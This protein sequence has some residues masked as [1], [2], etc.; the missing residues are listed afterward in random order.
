MINFYIYQ[1]LTIQT[2]C[3]CQALEITTTTHQG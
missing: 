3:N 2:P 1:L